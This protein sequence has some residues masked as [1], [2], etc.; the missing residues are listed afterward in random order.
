MVAFCIFLVF[1]SILYITLKFKDFSFNI[2]NSFS[3]SAILLE[4]FYLNIC[5][6]ELFEKSEPLDIDIISETSVFSVS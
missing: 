2:Y 3:N 6:N 5:I 1:L 4:V